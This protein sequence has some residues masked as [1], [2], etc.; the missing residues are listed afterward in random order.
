MGYVYYVARGEHVGPNPNPTSIQCAANH[1]SVE[2]C[3]NQQG[4]AVPLSYQCPAA[5][6]VC[7]DYV[8]DQHYGH[9]VG[10]PPSPPPGPPPPPPP[11]IHAVLPQLELLVHGTA[12]VKDI[13]WSDVTFSDAT[14][15]LPST[16]IGFVELQ[17]GHATP[18]PFLPFPSCLSQFLLAAI[19]FSVVSSV[20]RSH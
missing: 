12:G 18:L 6:P 11:P 14:W 9:C 16:A 2:P 3:C 8:L 15:L 13:S 7:V 5:S 4:K 10:A 19:V 1:G 17:A 20:V